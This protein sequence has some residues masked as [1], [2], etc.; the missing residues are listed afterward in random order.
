[1]FALM[2]SAGAPGREAILYFLPEEDLSTALVEATLQ[3]WMRSKLVSA[4][5]IA[6]QGKDWQE[7]TGEEK[8]KFGIEKH[9]TEMAYFLYSRNYVELT[10]AEKTKAD[11][12]RQSLEAK[13][14]GMAGKMDALTR[15]WADVT[16]GAVKLSGLT[17]PPNSGLT[18]PAS[19]IGWAGPK[20]QGPGRPARDTE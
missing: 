1:Q 12:C 6:S 15:F 4:A 16:S 8:I 7:M 10:G 20:A 14:A 18:T 17:P 11:T 3:S 2:L 5:I 19:S 9:Y 13:L